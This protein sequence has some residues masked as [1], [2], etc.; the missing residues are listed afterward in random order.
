MTVKATPLLATPPT[1]TTTLPVV[2][3]EGTGTV[4]LPVLHELGVASVPLKTTVLGPC[5]N[6]KFDPPIVTVVP[7]TPE[8]GLKPVTTGGGTVTMKFTTL[9][10]CC[11]ITTWTG[12]EIAPTGTGATIFVGLQLVGKA[13]LP[14]NERLLRP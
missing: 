11:P 9:L 12:P 4:M 10:N 1:V 6:P 13:K 8:V 3:P 14:V 2:A 7:T 5:D